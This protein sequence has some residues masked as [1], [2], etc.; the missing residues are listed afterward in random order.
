MDIR[1]KQTTDEMLV[2]AVR[3][4]GQTKAQLISSLIDTHFRDLRKKKVVIT[5][6]PEVYHMLSG[7]ADQ[8]GLSRENAIREL[9]EEIHPDYFPGLYSDE[10]PVTIT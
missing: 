3:L 1:L 9:V 5:F 7:I 8:L 10:Q 4:T 6:S 2:T